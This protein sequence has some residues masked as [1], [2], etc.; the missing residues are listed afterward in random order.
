TLVPT[1][2]NTTQPLF[3]NYSFTDIDG[4]SEVAMEIRW[5]KNNILQSDLNNLLS[6]PSSETEKGQEWNFTVKV[7][8]GTEWS[9]LNNSII[10]TISNAVPE[11]SNLDLTDNFDYDSE[12]YTDDDLLATWQAFDYDTNDI[13]SYNI[14][15][16]RNGT[17]Y[18]SWN[19]SDI[20]TILDN[21]NTSKNTNWTYIIKIYDGTIY[22][23]TVPLGYNI[24]IRNTPPIAEN[25]T[26]TS[27]PKSIDD[28]T[29]G[30]DYNDTDNDSQDSQGAIISWFKN[31]ENQ[32]SL[33]NKAII[34]AGNLSKNHVW[35]FT[36]QVSDGENHS[37]QIYESTHVVILNTEPL[38]SGVQLPVP[39]NPTRESGIMVNLNDI[40]LSFND[41]D[42]DNIE[43]IE[44]KWYKDNA[45]QTDLTGNLFIDGNLLIKGEVW[46]YSV[47]VTDSLSNSSILYSQEIP[48]VNSQPVIANT[49]FSETDVWT[50]NDLEII[51]QASDV[52][53]D[54]INVAGVHWYLFNTTDFSWDYIAIHDGLMILPSSITSKGE[55]WRFEIQVTDGSLV[56]VW[57]T[58]A[59]DVE[60]KNSVPKIQVASI[61]I[62]GGDNTSHSLT[63]DYFWFD[64]DPSDTEGL[65]EIVW[66]SG[67]QYISNES[68]N[69]PYKYTTAGERWWVTIRP[70][71]GEDFGEYYNS[72]QF[73]GTVIIGNTPPEVIVNETAI[74]GDLNGTLFIGST[75]GT[76]FDLV[77]K[78]N[79]TDIDGDQGAV[80]YDI[81]L[82]EGDYVSGA[83]YKWYRNRSGAVILVN[84]LNGKTNVP[85]YYTQRGDAWWCEIRPRD[86]Y[87]DFG[88]PENSTKVII[89][90]TEPVIQSINWINAFPTTND[91]ITFIL[92]YFDA[93]NDPMVESETF[94]CWFVN[95]NPVL[96]TENQT[97]L[98]SSYFAKNDNITVIV[99]PFDGLNWAA[100]NFTSNILGI[101]NSLP[102]L[103]NISLN[104]LIYNGNEVLYLNWSYYDLDGDLESSNWS[105]I[106]TRNGVSEPLFTNQ[107]YIPLINVS[108]GDL[109]RV[110]LRVNDGTEYSVT[111]VNQIYTKVLTLEYE[112]EPIAQI[113]PEVRTNEFYVEDENITISFNFDVP[114]DADSSLI[115]W[116]KIINKSIIQEEHTFENK[117]S[118]PFSATS[119]GEEW[120]C[121]ITPYDD[122]YYWKKINSTPIIIES[123]PSIETLPEDI[124]EALEDLEGH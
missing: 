50:L 11:A 124:V 24:S 51:F 102:Q 2:P 93:D 109:W 72:K 94:I 22:S 78:Y 36:V 40:L 29:A 71:D 76:M 73:G 122:F 97:I 86:L 52:D 98:Y 104:P 85:F 27:D 96:G 116:F 79:A 42:S 55:R 82:I 23:T 75:F 77:L 70:S 9:Q 3:A 60:I 26:I 30:W 68:I 87:G 35:W 49:Y 105:I 25:L 48:V 21:G 43:L 13:L 117:T 41:P 101:Q 91:N 63:L 118:I 106:W 19:T 95:G 80:A 4:D 37:I 111:H 53:N 120:Y 16:Y 59:F 83:D 38:L 32:T 88:A 64:D 5:Y 66:E 84:T 61:F 44:L 110:D 34:E 121:M 20:S 119:V 90:N 108:N 6:I 7:F 65:T 28:L 74:N 1:N 12:I 17:K 107:Y 89:G 115:Q 92:D 99:R 67:T 62:T 54:P 114:G 69:L 56:S 45:L 15:W 57:Q 39:T 10:I 14:T 58:T 81:V 113:S 31:G 112:F 46:N 103:S 18:I 123:R 8:D 33:F 47:I 100:I